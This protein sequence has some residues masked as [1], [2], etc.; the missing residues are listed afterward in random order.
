MQAEKHDA[1]HYLSALIQAIQRLRNCGCHSRTGTSIP[2]HQYVVVCQERNTTYCVLFR[3]LI[4]LKD[5]LKIGWIG[6]S[7]Y[8]GGENLQKTPSIFGMFLYNRMVVF[9]RLHGPE[10]CLELQFHKF[11]FIYGRSPSMQQYLIS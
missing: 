8:R 5:Q 9:A 6:M 7:R 2:L 3:V 10:T 1:G 4:F 11:I